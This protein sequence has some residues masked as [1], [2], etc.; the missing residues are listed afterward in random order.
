MASSS[1]QSDMRKVLR[2][3]GRE[4]RPAACGVC[5]LLYHRSTQSEVRTGKGIVG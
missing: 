3:T 4:G 1:A 5:L 2:A